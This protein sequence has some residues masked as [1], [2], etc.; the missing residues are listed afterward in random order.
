MTVKIYGWSWIIEEF[1]N[2]LV[3]ILQKWLK[4]K[5]YILFTI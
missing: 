5:N 3:Y 2:Q 1:R 4:L